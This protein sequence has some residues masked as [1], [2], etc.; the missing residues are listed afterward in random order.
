MIVIVISISVC[1]RLHERNHTP[2][3]A[4]RTRNNVHD[5]TLGSNVETIV[6]EIRARVNCTVSTTK[7]VPVYET[8]PSETV[9]F[10]AV[11]RPQNVTH[12]RI[13]VVNNSRVTRVLPN[14]WSR[15]EGQGEGRD[16]RR[17]L[18]SK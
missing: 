4:Y 16:G 2:T 9:R 5:N 1:V 8:V 10:F 7:N 3:S 15:Q 17:K 13:T 14:G 6:M 18:A 11:T 12:P